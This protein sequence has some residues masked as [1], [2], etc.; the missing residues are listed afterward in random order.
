MF[1]NHVSSNT[2]EGENY[3]I[4]QQLS[5]YLIKTYQG[6]LAGKAPV[7]NAKYLLPISK[8]QYLTV[9]VANPEDL[10]KTEN[11]LASFANRAGYLI[12]R[13]SQRLEELM[14]K[15]QSFTSAFQSIQW[16]GIR[17]ARAH[18]M[19]TIL[20]SFVNQVEKAKEEQP[21]L[22]SV[23]KSL[24]DL[25][26]LY[27]TERDLGDFLEASQ[28]SPVQAG[29]IHEQVEAIL[30][31]IRPN[32]V[33]LVDAFNHSDRDLN[34]ALGRYDGNVYEALFEWTKRDPMNKTDVIECYEDTIKPIIT[35]QYKAKL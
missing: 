15:G 23:L 24:C 21:A 33:A 9:T 17:A 18:C 31:E 34:S 8:R 28:Y 4:I 30:R 32:A 6:A 2:L 22:Y 3:V 19:Y 35:K 12:S 29:W 20:V 13:T 1:T 5:R 26:A 10:R 14:A 25:F 27:H 16:L 7:G 11:Q